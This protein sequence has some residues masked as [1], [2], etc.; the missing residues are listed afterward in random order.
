MGSFRLPVRV[1][2]KILARLK[3]ARYILLFF[4]LAG[5]MTV[6]PLLHRKAGM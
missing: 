2:P 5:T 1:V 4:A 3:A 6:G